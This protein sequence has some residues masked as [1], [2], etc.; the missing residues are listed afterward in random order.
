MRLSSEAIVLAAN[1]VFAFLCILIG[2]FSERWVLMPL[3]FGIGACW[4]AT[5]TTLNA[6]AQVYLPRK[7]RARGMSAYLMCF[8]LGMAIG[9][10]VWG[11]LAY[12]VG[13]N[14]A[15][16]TSGLFMVILSGRCTGAQ[17]A[18]SI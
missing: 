6:T 18:R 16:V 8:A 3:L 10:A 14:I 11:W 2:L 17:S 9:S 12:F 15:F 13:L 1:L 7:F 4:M 5:M